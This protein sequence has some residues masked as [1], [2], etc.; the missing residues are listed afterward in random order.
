MLS[1]SEFASQVDRRFLE[2]EESYESLLRLGMLLHKV[3]GIPI[4]FAKSTT[5]VVRSSTN[6]SGTGGVDDNEEVTLATITI[7]AGT[8]QNRMSMWLHAMWTNTGGASTKT[9]IVRINGASVGTLAATTNPN[10]QISMVIHS[11]NALNAQKVVNNAGGGWD[12]SSGG[13]MISPTADNNSDVT[14]T[15]S[16]TWGAAANGENITLQEYMLMLVPG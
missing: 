13:A 3:C 9:M 6:T 16:C 1:Q 8:L 11:N 10:N 2:P 12:A 15:L 14:I 5:P 7:P 4:V